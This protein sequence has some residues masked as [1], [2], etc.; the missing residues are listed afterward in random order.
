MESIDIYNSFEFNQVKRVGR[1]AKLIYNF[2]KFGRKGISKI[3][4]TTVYIDAV[5]SVGES[6]VS[7]YQYQKAKEITKQLTIDLNKIKHEFENKKKEFK[8]RE[9]T[10]KQNAKANIKLTQKELED[11]KEKWGTILKT[12]Y[13]HSK[14]YLYDCKARLENIRTEYPASDRIKEIEKK[15]KDATEAYINATLS[16]I[17]G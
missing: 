9:Y 1:N 6:I 2:A 14:K 11:A 13:E 3:N 15:Y 4:P 5:I 7:F 10:I 17:G 16:I 12:V 8:E